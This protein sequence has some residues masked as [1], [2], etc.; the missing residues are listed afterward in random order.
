MFGLV[1]MRP[2]SRVMFT[3]RQGA[4]R[5]IDG[6]WLAGWEGKSGVA[7]PKRE[8]EWVVDAWIGECWVSVHVTCS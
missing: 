1:D 3:G 6:S 7:M 8:R 4:D 5:L 2:P